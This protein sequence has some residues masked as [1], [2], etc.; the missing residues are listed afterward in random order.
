MYLR[1]S[2]PAT[3]WEVVVVT[4]TSVNGASV[5]YAS[6]PSVFRQNWKGLVDEHTVPG[7]NVVAAV[8]ASTSVTQLKA[9]PQYRSTDG[10]AFAAAVVTSHWELGITI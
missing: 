8:P 9:V 6:T 5:L 4:K 7:E 3:P 10:I 2:K 1:I